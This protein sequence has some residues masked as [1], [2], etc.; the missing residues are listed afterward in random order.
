MKYRILLTISFL[1]LLLSGCTKDDLSVCVTSTAFKC[2]FEFNDGQTDQFAK[3][4]NK[5]DLYIFDGSGLLV[6]HIS[7]T[8]D[9]LPEGYTV[10][11][12]LNYGTYTAVLYG[13]VGSNKEV[14]V[15]TKQGNLTTALKAM[16]EGESRMSDMRLMLNSITGQ[17]DRDLE[18]ILHGMVSN[19]EVTSVPQKVP[20]NVSFISNTNVIE[21]NISGLENLISEPHSITDQTRAINDVSV[22]IEGNNKAYL[23][24]NTLDMELGKVTHAPYWQKFSN[25]IL[26]SRLSVLRLFKEYP[27]TLK[28][29]HGNNNIWQLN[30]TA[31]IMKSPDYTTNEDLDREDKFIINVKITTAGDITIT[32]NGW[33]TTASSEII[34]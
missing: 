21:L 32:V 33:T 27:M 8:Q 13:T 15:G 16:K 34:G 6:K 1:L 12:D 25:N 4:V 10:T 11:T 19:F 26:V 22:R 2:R 17:T 23:Y 30:L 9:Y 7:H 14:S 5:V 18:V 29:Y 24:D 28:I 31:E 3:L 20:H